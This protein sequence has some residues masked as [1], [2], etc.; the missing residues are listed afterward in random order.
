MLW[1]LVPS[2]EDSSTSPPSRRARSGTPA[3]RGARFRAASVRGDVSFPSLVRV[4]RETGGGAIPSAALARKTAIAFI[5]GGL[6]L[7][8]LTQLALH[9]WL[10]SFPFALAVFLE[11]MALQAMTKG[12]DGD[13][14]RSLDRQ[15]INLR[16]RWPD[17]DAVLK[18]FGTKFCVADPGGR[19]VRRA[20]RRHAKAHGSGVDR[21]AVV[22][23]VDSRDYRDAGLDDRGALTVPSPPRPFVSLNLIYILYS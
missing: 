9:R 7:G 1:A 10:P 6:L 23:G 11:G 20:H 15:Y 19:V 14:A 2:S 18:S 16:T 5:G 8:I 4:R 22:A 13:F 3:R 17:S 21:R 12:Q